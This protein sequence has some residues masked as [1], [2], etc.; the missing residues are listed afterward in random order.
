[1]F[2]PGLRQMALE[3]VKDYKLGP[4]FNTAVHE[5]NPQGLRG[6]VQCPGND[7]ETNTQGG[8]AMDPQLGILF[9]ESRRSC[10]ARLLVPG[11]DRDVPDS[12]FTFGRSINPWVT[13]NSNLPG[14]EG[15][16]IFRPPYGS[17]TAI[18]MNTGEHLWQI[19]NGD[20]PER[21]RNHPRLQGVDIPNTGQPSHATVLVT[22]SLLMYGE[23]RGAEPRFHAV[24]KRTGERIGT[25]E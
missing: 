6:G 14:P 25:I 23:G 16:P 7:G 20:T 24:D 21:I 10:V 8:S 19:P 11:T 4:L 5:G 12:P 1:D 17:I 18:D 22:R 13:R 2:T 3:I 15:L 9:V